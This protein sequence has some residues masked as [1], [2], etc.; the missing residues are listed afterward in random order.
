MF[1]GR[2]FCGYICPLG[3]LQELVFA[4]RRRRSKQIPF[5]YERKLAKFKYILLPLNIILVL[6]GL[7]WLYIN[8]C[9]IYGLS[10]LPSLAVGG[11]IIFILIMVG[12]IFVERLWCRYLCPYAALLNLAQGL[13]KLLGTK[14]RMIYRN[15]ERCIDCELCSRNCPMNLDILASEYVQDHN[16]IHCLR[17]T[18]KCPKPG[19]V[20]RG[21]RYEKHLYRSDRNSAF[22]HRH[23]AISCSPGCIAQTGKAGSVSSGC[24]FDGQWESCD[25]Q[26]QMHWLSPLCRWL[27]RY[28]DLPVNEESVQEKSLPEEPE[29]ISEELVNEPVK[30]TVS[31]PNVEKLEQ[32]PNLKKPL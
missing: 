18:V 10:R 7:S 22:C 31:A 11:L 30:E 28:P 14:R 20:C 27:C 3:T 23:N 2:I 5:M 29:E 32:K 12:G 13:G 26:H 6:L 25:R 9:P 19:T 24:H 8:F 16:C 1:Q 21:K 4:V 17:C 15:L